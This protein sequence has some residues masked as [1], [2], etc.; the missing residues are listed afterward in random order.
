MSHAEE[1][2]GP[3]QF[4]T[5]DELAQVLEDEIVA[6]KYAVGSK[7]P[8]ERQLALKYNVSRPVVR[9]A[10]R[11][12]TERRLVSIHPSRGAF[13]R[14][15]QSFDAASHMA[16]LFRRKNVTPRHLVEARQTLECAAAELAAERASPADISMMRQTL[17]QLAGASDVVDQAQ[18]DLGFHFAIARASGNPVIEAMFSVVAP[19]MVDVML[20]SLFDPKVR[21]EALGMHDEIVEAIA[22]HRPADAR[23]AMRRHIQVAEHLYGEDL[24]IDVETVAR[25]EFVRRLAPEV[26]L[27]EAVERVLQQSGFSSD[28]SEGADT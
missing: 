12:L 21:S 16:V 2:F 25:R 5:R 14:D 22:S 1:A 23:D 4:I 11:M 15:A 18:F 8:S 13:V 19:P 28:M 9:E 3:A 24:D 10:L 26:T 6:G 27:E 17:D 7:L 20:R